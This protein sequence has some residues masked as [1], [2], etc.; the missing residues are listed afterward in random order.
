MT[1]IP[2]RR[3]LPLFVVDDAGRDVLGRTVPESAPRACEG[4]GVR[5]LR[6]ARRDAVARQ[7][8]TPQGQ[9]YLLFVPRAAEPRPS[10]P[11]FLE[12]W[13]LI[14]IGTASSLAVSALLAWYLARPIRNLRWGVQ[15]GGAGQA[16][17]ARAPPHGPQAR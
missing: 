5:A 4:F 10:P 12:P 9:R 1:E 7:V 11:P 14:V 8:T 17:H 3:R 16:R 13:Q 6:Q 15:R 2:N